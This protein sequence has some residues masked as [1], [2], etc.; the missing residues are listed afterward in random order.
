M[1]FCK[2]RRGCR[3]GMLA[4]GLVLGTGLGSPAAEPEDSAAG[5][6][7]AP[8]GAHWKLVW[9]DEFDGKRL[10]STKWDIP[11]Y[12]RRKAWW[13]RRAISL[14]G[15]G[16]LV[17]RIFR[18]GNKFYDGCVRTRGRFEHAFGYYVARIRLQKSRGHWTAFWLMG[19]GVGRVGDGGRDG[20]EID[21]MEKPWIDD[22]VQHT[23][24]WDGYGR[25]HRSKG[26]VSRHP[27]IMQGFHTFALLWTPKEYVFY[28]DGAECWRTR[29][30][31]VCQTP[32]YIKLSDEAQF[33]GWAGDVRKAHL[34]DEFLVDYV[35]VFDL[36]DD[37]TG[38]CV[39]KPVWRPPAK[40]R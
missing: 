37:K 19:P 23:L 26:H 13:S 18:E 24:H 39:W 3:W 1:D 20:T 7:P 11:E 34:P 17:I 15:K 36:V 6:P 32:L 27:G 38:K 28:V 16:R 14:D 29:A 5:L 21:I 30:G 9:H 40:K 31:G 22:R 35:R 2:T 8:R 33:R 25:H 10:D 4:F 12:K